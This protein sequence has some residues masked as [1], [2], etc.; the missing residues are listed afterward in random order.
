MSAGGFEVTRHVSREFG[1]S[2]ASGTAMLHHALVK[3]FLDGW[4]SAVGSD[5]EL[6]AGIERRLN[7]RG[8]LRFE[9][10]MLYI[11]GVRR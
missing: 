6:W 11:E 1:L 2:F 8:P 9:V 3:W 7:A 4:R 5:R 10:P